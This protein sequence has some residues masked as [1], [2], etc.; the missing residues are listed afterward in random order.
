[1]LHLFYRG[2]QLRLRLSQ[3]LVQISR[4]TRP[5][6]SHDFRRTAARNLV[7]A[8]VSERTCMEILGHKTRSMFDRYNITREK[9]LADAMQ[10]LE[11]FHQATDQKVVAIAK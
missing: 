5:N 6:R 10:R 11:Q 1:M 3:R 8:G 9:D 2:G 7:R 4:C